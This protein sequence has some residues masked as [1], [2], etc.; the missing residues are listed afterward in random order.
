MGFGVYSSAAM[1]AIANAGRLMRLANNPWL[2]LLT[3]TAVPGFSGMV[4]TPTSM[5]SPNGAQAYF[6]VVM[7]RRESL[8]MAAAAPL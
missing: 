8:V 7:F 4:A 1:Q 5:S 2:R 6:I 3:A